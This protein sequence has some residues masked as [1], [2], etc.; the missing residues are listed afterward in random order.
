[1]FNNADVTNDTYDYNIARI[2]NCHLILPVILLPIFWNIGFLGNIVAI[3]N[4]TGPI[5]RTPNINVSFLE[6]L[7]IK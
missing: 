2:K 1:M 3:I 5:T 4:K 7:I 6:V